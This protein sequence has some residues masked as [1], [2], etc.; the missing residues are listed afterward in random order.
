VLTV[1]A[2][3]VVGGEKI[4]AKLGA[5]LQKEKRNVG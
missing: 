2:D 1:Q 3:F 4:T 5:K